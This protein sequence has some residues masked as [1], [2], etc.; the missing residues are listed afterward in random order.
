MILEGAIGDAYGAGFEFAEYDKIRNKNNVSQYETHPLFDEINGKYTDDTQMAIAIAELLLEHQTWTPLL[1][2]N[3]FVEVFKR[4][5]RRGY[6]K[7]FFQFLSD[8]SDG[9]E[10][11][12]KIKPKSE[13]NGAAMRA[14]PLG[15]LRTEKEILEKC[16]L[17]A[18]VTHQSDRA[19]IAAQAISLTAHFFIYNK[20]TKAQLLEYLKDIQNH[21]WNA[22]WEGEVKVDAIDT[23]E[24]TLTVLLH[25]SH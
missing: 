22:N 5:V 20:G 17:Q 23:V 15:I 16:D 11:I 12:N 7:R 14:Y 9:Q 4:D 8:I 21:R 25:H 3:K 24:A 13:R 18:Q 1:V 6:A 10:L 19:I 2:A